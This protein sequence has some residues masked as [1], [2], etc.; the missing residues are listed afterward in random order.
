VLLILLATFTSLALAL[1]TSHQS[2]SQL[3]SVGSAVGTLASIA[4]RSLPWSLHGDDV[5]WSLFAAVFCVTAFTSISAYVS[6]FVI[7]AFCR[8]SL[9]TNVSETES[10]QMSLEL[11]KN[12]DFLN[13]KKWN[14]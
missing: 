1:F 11:V 12:L 3:T 5:V 13:T 7:L 2:S 6:H 14:F 9:R 4:T 10:I 8:L